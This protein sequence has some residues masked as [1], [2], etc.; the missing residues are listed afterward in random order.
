[1]RSGIKT[2]IFILVLCAFRCPADAAEPPFSSRTATPPPPG[3]EASSRAVALMVGRIAS[4]TR[5]PQNLGRL[6][7]CVVGPARFAGAIAQSG[8][9][10]RRPVTVRSLTTPN[11]STLDGCNIVYLGS[12]YMNSLAPGQLLRV[13]SLLREQ[14][15]LSIAEVDPACR[16]GAMFC[17]Q[18]APDRLSFLL[19]VDAIAR[20]PLRV[21]PRVLR[22]AQFNGVEP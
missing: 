12:V 15:V 8:E 22:L 7:V 11:P 19:N 9:T 3:T 14:A 6:L 21:D 10:A 13:L 20:S 16:S 17:L 5:W 18:V 2:V 1:M 4:F